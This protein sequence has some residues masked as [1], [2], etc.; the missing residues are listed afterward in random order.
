MISTIK[1]S[2]AKY[3]INADILCTVNHYL[4]ARDY[5]SLIFVSSLANS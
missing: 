3:K 4:F 1:C 2:V 5:I